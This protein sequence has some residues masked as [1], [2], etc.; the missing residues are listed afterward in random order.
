LQLY[1]YVELKKLLMFLRLE[2]SSILRKTMDQSWR[3]FD[4]TGVKFD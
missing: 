1:M 4:D 2:S 3:L